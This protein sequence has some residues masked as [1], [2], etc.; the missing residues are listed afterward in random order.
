LLLDHVEAGL[1][2]IHG[3]DRSEKT[4]KF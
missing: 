2:C 1:L 3:E 4:R